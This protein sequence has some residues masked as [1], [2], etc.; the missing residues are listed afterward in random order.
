MTK[1]F[2]GQTFP[3]AIVGAI[4]DLAV[5]YHG[6]AHLERGGP[7]NRARSVFANGETPRAAAR[8]AARQ[9]KGHVAEVRVAAELSLDSGLRGRQFDCALNELANHPHEDVLVQQGRFKLNGAQI[10]VGHARYLADKARRS[11]AGQL[12]VNTEALKAVQDDWNGS[13]LFAT[14]MLHHEDTRSAKLSGTRAEQDATAML[15]KMILDEPTVSFQLKASVVVG[16]GAAGF[17]TS[18]GRSLL[19]QAV[20]RLH[21]EQRFEKSMLDNAMSSGIE[22]M[23]RTVLATGLQV[24]RFLD[25]AGSAFNGRLLRALGGS[26]AVAGAIAEVVVSTAKEVVAWTKNE[27]TFDELLR[28]FGVNA[29]SAGG[30]LVG[31]AIMLG[32]TAGMPGWLTALL[33][34]IGAAGGGYLG[35]KLGEDLFAP[36]WNLEPV[37]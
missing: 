1:H 23:K 13:S 18:F 35:H 36:T 12:V 22:A 28:R 8:I 2:V 4:A 26:A 10:G 9:G 34:A 19:F 32:L 6:P 5:H 25:H 16:S 31:G 27:I 14:D 11:R 3:H 33:T 17:A 20:H 37:I 15:E 24:G 29:F 21:T 30:A 7:A